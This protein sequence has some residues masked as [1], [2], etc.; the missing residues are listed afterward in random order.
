MG[1]NEKTYDILAVNLRSHK[2][3]IIGEEKT[4]ADAEAYQNIAVIRRGVNEEF[5]VTVPHG[6]YDEGADWATKEDSDGK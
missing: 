2:V 6:S 5:F 3:R 1:I 4:K